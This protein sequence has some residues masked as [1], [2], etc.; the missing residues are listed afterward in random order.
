MYVFSHHAYNATLY[1]SILKAL[2]EVFPNA[3]APD[4][5]RVFP[6]AVAPS[7]GV[8]SA[9]LEVFTLARA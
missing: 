7:L 9:K 3:G 1:F 2:K 6:N 8:I 5:N 4:F